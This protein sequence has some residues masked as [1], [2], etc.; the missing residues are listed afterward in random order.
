MMNKFKVGEK[1]YLMIPDSE[2]TE[3]CLDLKTYHGKAFKV[4]KAKTLYGGE[5]FNNA[6]TYYELEGVISKKGIPYSVASEWL[7]KTWSDM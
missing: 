7:F 2:M 4:K 1:V 3:N 5:K 6:R